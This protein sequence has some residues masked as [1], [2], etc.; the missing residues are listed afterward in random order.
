MSHLIQMLKNQVQFL[1]CYNYVQ[2]F[3]HRRVIELLQNGNFPD[4]RESWVKMTFLDHYLAAIES[5]ALNYAA[6]TTEN[7][8]G[9]FFDCSALKMIKCKPLQDISE[10]FLPK[11]D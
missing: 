2:K 10:L 3:H 6:A 7:Y 1:I 9:W 5:I 4:Q 8:T 11:S